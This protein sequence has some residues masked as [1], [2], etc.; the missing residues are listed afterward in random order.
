MNPFNPGNANP[1]SKTTKIIQSSPVFQLTFLPI[2]IETLL[3]LHTLP[4]AGFSMVEAQKVKHTV[5]KEP[6]DFAPK[7]Y[8][9]TS[10]LDFSP[11]KRDINFAE[12][13][14]FIVVERKHVR[15]TGLFPETGIEFLDKKIGAQNNVH[16]LGCRDF[17]PLVDEPGNGPKALTRKDNRLMFVKKGYRDSAPIRCKAHFSIFAKKRD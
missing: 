8:F 6:F 4:V 11:L 17:L 12:E 15:G 7:G 2:A 9:E 16:R 13:A 14:F 3:G 1:S 5:H 10:C